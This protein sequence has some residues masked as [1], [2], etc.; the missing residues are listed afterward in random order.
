MKQR[1]S[2]LPLSLFGGIWES[3]ENSPAIFVN[4]DGKIVYIAS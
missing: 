2:F 3:D 1:P 4:P